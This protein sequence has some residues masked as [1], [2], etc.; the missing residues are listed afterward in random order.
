MRVNG[1]MLTPRRPIAKKF[2]DSSEHR[3]Q[4]NL[5]KE[6]LPEYDALL[7]VSYINYITYNQTVGVLCLDIRS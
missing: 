5:E 3:E 6:D 7:P 2:K 4:F 1:G